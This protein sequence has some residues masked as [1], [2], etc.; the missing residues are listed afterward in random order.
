[1][2]MTEA[3]KFAAETSPV[4]KA[5]GKRIFS[6]RTPPFKNFPFYI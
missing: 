3:A 4:V 1:M 6:N 2:K 5:D